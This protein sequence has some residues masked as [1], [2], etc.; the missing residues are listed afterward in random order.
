MTVS[1]AV[2]TWGA[3]LFIPF[4]F[5]TV[6]TIVPRMVAKGPRMIVV[7]RDEQALGNVHA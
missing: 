6:E 3:E 1:D 5:S 2:N 4:C 7:P